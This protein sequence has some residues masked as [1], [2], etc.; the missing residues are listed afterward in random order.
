MTDDNQMLRL[1]DLD[2]ASFPRG[3]KVLVASSCAMPARR[4]F[5]TQ[6]GAMLAPCDG[7]VINAGIVGEWQQ[8]DLPRDEPAPVLAVL[9]V[10]AECPHAHAHRLS[11]A[12]MA[13]SGA[14]ALE[15]VVLPEGGHEEGHAAGHEAGHGGADEAAPA[16]D[17]QPEEQADHL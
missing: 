14:A 12:F 7:A 5:V 10:H 2:P 9:L 1:I 4:W 13:A 15:M 8:G 6:L 11:A 3:G 16:A 17:E